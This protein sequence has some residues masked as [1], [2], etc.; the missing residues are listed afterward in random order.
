MGRGEDDSRHPPQAYTLRSVSKSL[1]SLQIAYYISIPHYTPISQNCSNIY[2]FP[3]LPYIGLHKHRY[4]F[5]ESSHT[6]TRKW[7][8]PPVTLLPPKREIRFSLL[9]NVELGFEHLLRGV[10]VFMMW[11]TEQRHGVSI[12]VG[13][14]APTRDRSSSSSSIRVTSF[15]F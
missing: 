11:T 8:A 14:D 9:S 13:K 10:S 12:I 7:V 5:I 1:G 15:F 2:T 4:I 3:H 6:H